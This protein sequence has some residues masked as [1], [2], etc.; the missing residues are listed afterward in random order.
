MEEKNSAALPRQQNWQCMYNKFLDYLPC[1]NLWQS[2]SY[3]DYLWL[4][5]AFIFFSAR[6]RAEF[7]KSSNLIGS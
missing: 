4:L 7:N 1:E 5:K 2:I 3:F 6:E